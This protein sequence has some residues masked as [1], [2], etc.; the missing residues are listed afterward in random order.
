MSFL[1]YKVLKYII[2]ICSSAF[3]SRAMLLGDSQSLYV[4]RRRDVLVLL[5]HRIASSWHQFY[6][7]AKH[8][9]TS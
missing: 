2:D 3:S 7:R 8:P 5:Q 9:A 4:T 1:V 6:F